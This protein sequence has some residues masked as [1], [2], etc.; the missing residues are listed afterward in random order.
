MSENAIESS[1][2]LRVVLAASS[3]G[4]SPMKVSAVNRRSHMIA[5]PFLVAGMSGIFA[6]VAFAQSPVT[7]GPGD[8]QLFLDDRAVQ[9]MSGL[10]RTMHQLEKRGAVIKP[11]VPSDGCR[12]QT[13]STSPMWVPEEGVYKMVYMAFP[14]ENHN[15]IGAAYAVSKDGIHWEKP[16]L[17]QN[18]KVRGSTKN[19]RIFVDRNLRWGDN[20]LFNVVYDPDD[21]DPSRRYKGLLGSINRKPVVSKDCIHWRILD[22]P[23]IPSSDTSTLT[24]D[25]K[26]RRFLAFVKTGNKYGRAASLSISKDFENWTRPAFCFG[27]DAEDQ[28][29]APE[30]IQERLSDPG[31]VNPLFVAP[32][33]AKRGKAKG[34]GRTLPTWRCECYSF[35]AFPYE[36]V[37]IGVGMMYYPTGTALP[38]RNNTDGF[39]MI[40]LV[41]SRD[42]KTWTRLGNREEF[43]APSRIDKGLIGVFDRQQIC[44]PGQPLDMGDELWFYYTGFK[45]RIPM[46]SL[47]PDGSKRD[48]KTLTPQE[49]AD[50][51]DGWSAICLGVLRRDGF[52]SLDAGQKGGY[53]VTR[54]FK[55][56]G[57]GLFLNAEVEEAGSAHVEVLEEDGTGIPGFSRSEAVPLDGKGVSQQAVWQTGA[58]WG[59]LK[60][61]T[62]RLKIY[63]NKAK[64]YSFWVEDGKI[65]P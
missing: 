17:G 30:K 14:M 57:A 64:L 43:V 34:R 4:K 21:P 6:F 54:P 58:Y 37:Y 3:Y 28:K 29:L 8:R 49:R 12:V 25:R 18:V 23:P 39:D 10:K 48:P 26:T 42:L 65:A 2:R 44:A 24:Y 45:T 60:S 63:M 9:K 32:H 52:V 15:E 33:P 56:K 16:D 50:L 31:L 11:D 20:S 1:N 55:A 27:A 47:N 51:D 22:V 13:Y 35:A 53:L 36:D 46:Y 62:V 59:M 7:V 40:Q 5:L 41:M 38:A 61:K 19:N